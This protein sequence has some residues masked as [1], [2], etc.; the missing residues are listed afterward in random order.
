MIFRFAVSAN[1]YFIFAYSNCVEGV[2]INKFQLYIYIYIIK[3]I[4][5]ILEDIFFQSKEIVLRN[6]NLE[7]IFGN[8]N[9]HKLVIFFDY[10]ILK[11]K[12]FNDGGI[13]AKI[14]IKCDSRYNFYFI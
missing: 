2:C 5:Q 11:I 4:V 3:E 14:Y 9:Y 13:F 12:H 8:Y 10:F 1:G 7:L 6:F